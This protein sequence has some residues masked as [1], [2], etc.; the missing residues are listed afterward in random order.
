MASKADQDEGTRPQDKRLADIMAA[1]RR[2]I[3]AKGYENVRIA[4]IA[5][6]ADVVDGTVY[7]YFENKRDLLV[8][9]TE[10]WFE[11]NI[12]G[13]SGVS[14]I[15]GTR[16]KLRHLMRRLLIFVRK[17]PV[18][19][20]FVL[21][22]MRPDPAFRASRAFAMNRRMTEEVS[23]V[24][25]QAM[26]SGEFRTDLPVALVR[27][28]IFGCLEHRIWAFL[29]GEGDF[30]VDEVADGI[31]TVICRG[32]AARSHGGADPLASATQRLTA[33]AARLED[34]ER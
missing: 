5:K 24:C 12:A 1:A 6:E 28:L 17:E 8:R 13:D 30:D 32:M 7:R 3:R 29:R 19:N 25:R 2:A 21:M 22:E 11:E 18:L 31:A 20:R 26:A 33:L 15:A 16:N 4:D 10:A 9:V 14:D 23:E 27:D 34:L